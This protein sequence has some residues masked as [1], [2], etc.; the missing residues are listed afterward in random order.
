MQFI[1]ALKPRIRRDGVLIPIMGNIDKSLEEKLNI[2]LAK[3]NGVL[4]PDKK[5]IF[6]KERE[7]DENGLYI[8]E[9]KGFE[10]GELIIRSGA[11]LKGLINFHGKLRIGF[12]NE[13]WN[14]AFL[15]TEIT[16]REET[17][18]YILGQENALGSITDARVREMLTAFITKSANYP[19]ITL[20]SVLSS[21]QGM[22]KDKSGEEQKFEG[23]VSRTR[24][25]LVSMVLALIGYAANTPD[26]TQKDRNAIDKA[27]SNLYNAW[28]TAS[29][30][31]ET[32]GREAER[33]SA[34]I[35]NHILKELQTKG[36]CAFDLTSDKM[37]GANGGHAQTGKVIKKADGKYYFEYYNKGFGS[38]IE[39]V[40]SK[41]LTYGK[42]SFELTG[43]QPRE[44]AD[45]IGELISQGFTIKG[46]DQG[47]QSTLEGGLENYS[48][49]SKILASF[50]QAKDNHN[51]KKEQ[52]SKGQLTGNCTYASPGEAIK[53]TLFSDNPDNPGLYN[54]VLAYTIGQT[55]NDKMLYDPVSY[56]KESIKNYHDKKEVIMTPENDSAYLN[57][58]R[59]LIKDTAEMKINWN[60]AAGELG[61]KV[62]GAGLRFDGS[63]YIWVLGKNKNGEETQYQIQAN[64]NNTFD[65]AFDNTFTIDEE[66]HATNF[67]GA[68]PKRPYQVIEILKK[69]GMPEKNIKALIALPAPALYTTTT[70]VDTDEISNFR[71]DLEKCKNQEIS[72]EANNI[73]NFIFTHFDAPTEL[74]HSK[75][76]KKQQWFAPKDKILDKDL[77]ELFNLLLKH[78]IKNSEDAPREPYNGKIY[79]YD[80]ISENEDKAILS[81]IIPRYRFLKDLEGCKADS[82]VQE[83]EN[84][85]KFIAQNFDTP[86]EKERKVAQ[87]STTGKE[88]ILKQNFF[89]PNEQ[90]ISQEELKELYKLLRKHNIKGG[91]NLA[92]EPFEG[93]IYLYNNETLE[94]DDFKLFSK[95]L[96]Y[97]KGPSN[98]VLEASKK[99]SK[100]GILEIDGSQV[101]S[102]NSGNLVPDIIYLNLSLH[103][104]SYNSARA[105]PICEFKENF[106]L[107]GHTFSSI[108]NSYGGYI[109]AH[110]ISN[111][112]GNYYIKRDKDLGFFNQNAARVEENILH[113]LKSI[114][115][116]EVLKAL[117]M[118]P[119]EYQIHFVIRDHPQGKGKKLDMLVT[120][121]GIEGEEIVTKNTLTELDQA[122][123]KVK[124]AAALL[125][126]NDVIS[127]KGIHNIIRRPDKSQKIFDPFTVSNKYMENYIESGLN[128]TDLNAMFD[129]GDEVEIEQIL[130]AAYEKALKFYQ[131]NL[132]S[133]AP[134]LRVATIG[135]LMK[136]EGSPKNVDPEKIETS[137]NEYFASCENQLQKFHNTKVK[138]KGSVVHTLSDSVILLKTPN[139]LNFIYIGHILQI[140]YASSLERDE[141]LKALKEIIGDEFIEADSKENFVSIKKG[142][143]GLFDGPGSEAALRMQDSVKCDQ[144]LEALHL[145][146]DF[147]GYKGN[148]NKSIFYFHNLKNGQMMN[149]GSAE[150]KDLPPIEEQ[151]ENPDSILPLTTVTSGNETG[152]RIC[153]P[154]GLSQNQIQAALEERLPVSLLEETPPKLLS[155]NYPNFETNANIS[156]GISNIRAYQN[157]GFPAD[158]L[159]S[160]IVEEQFEFDIAGVNGLFLKKDRPDYNAVVKN[161]VLDREAAI[162]RMAA[163][164]HIAFTNLNNMAVSKDQHKIVTLSGIGL[165]AFAG[166]F[167][168]VSIYQQALELVLLNNTYSNIVGVYYSP[169]RNSDHIEPKNEI[170]PNGIKLIVDR[171][172]LPILSKPN[173]MRKLFGLENQENVGISTFGACD[174]LSWFLNEW[175]E[176]RSTSQEAAFGLQTNALQRA[177]H[178]A[179]TPNDAVIKNHGERHKLTSYCISYTPVHSFDIPTLV[180]NENE[181]SIHGDSIEDSDSE[182]EFDITDDLTQEET[183][184][185]VSSLYAML[186]LVKY[187]PAGLQNQYELLSENIYI[188]AGKIVDI[189]QKNID[190]GAT[191][192]LKDGVLIFTGGHYVIGKLSTIYNDNDSPASGILKIADSALTRN[193]QIMQAFVSRLEQKNGYPIT[194]EY[195]MRNRQGVNECGIRSIISHFLVTKLHV[196]IEELPR[197]LEDKW[198]SLLHKEAAANEEGNDSEYNEE[199][200]NIIRSGLNNL[201]QSYVKYKQESPPAV[202]SLIQDN[203]GP[204]E[205]H[206]LEQENQPLSENNNELLPN[207]SDN[208]L[209]L[210]GLIN[211]DLLEEKIEINPSPITD[212]SSKAVN[213]SS[214]N[215]NKKLNIGKLRPFSEESRVKIS[216]MLPAMIKITQGKDEITSQ[217]RLNRQQDLDFDSRRDAY[218][219]VISKQG[220]DLAQM[221]LRKEAINLLCADIK[222][223]YSKEKHINKVDNLIKLFEKALLM[224]DY[225]AIQKRWPNSTRLTEIIKNNPAELKIATEKAIKTLR[226]I[227]GESMAR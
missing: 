13:N 220:T 207:S 116:L 208:L 32:P 157:M 164:F 18:E 169:A 54:D 42:V 84:L 110:K 206:P 218:Q 34:N 173:V 199:T 170:L 130:K 71:S 136:G 131:D 91:S 155:Q 47:L 145:I 45:E 188:D 63:P 138:D 60:E 81:Q 122:D 205:Y 212:N 36:E 12:V 225:N 85:S 154:E 182:E 16:S 28:K 82:T 19:D 118:G 59:N 172:E 144:L 161:G 64:G 99:H 197:R 44:I 113:S 38:Y 168:V 111:S 25:R 125:K 133:I 86:I 6:I 52:L 21:L 58:L 184:V 124:Y 14:I 181:P 83:F 114:F 102:V 17:V 222:E 10:S 143:M 27:I 94:P 151:V 40:N 203:T 176:R 166:E 43:M 128:K 227:K 119:E 92:R 30:K 105:S 57:N 187:L 214:L 126:L 167:E 46:N 216:K 96:E 61:L 135:S 191:N 35:S 68:S 185:D 171:Q 67:I 142:A 66:S 41:E 198:I 139:P 200:Q 165:G 192:A 29:I 31:F 183:L 178:N 153:Y 2:Q 55:Q 196:P 72:V 20:S 98:A 75:N 224:G 141:A 121:K 93:K 204:V 48:N 162:K 1:E 23:S 217:Y 137:F 56:L 189:T 49:G 112:S 3:C 9:L 195:H 7:K 11:G 39:I 117:K 190:N 210:S 132:K 175:L 109:Y 69:I 65:H 79:L 107:S 226:D 8:G 193:I 159:R 156:F 202:D 158:K 104:N 15:R 179:K 50:N 100:S 97:Q 74:I 140:Q 194:L 4:S 22:I 215:M 127:E 147:H 73:A 129:I 70:M 223:K 76:G 148:T 152:I 62:K 213:D 80:D 201:I 177:Y 51:L 209:K 95:V 103:N 78:G 26:L 108:P 219:S 163:R 87:H 146:E 106:F 24:F 37:Q 33:V 123:I 89:I 149:F 53:S 120:T 160:Y 77:Q 101:I 186:A 134:L 221:Y 211:R 180:S 150:V 174:P 115:A 5:S 88:E 90:G